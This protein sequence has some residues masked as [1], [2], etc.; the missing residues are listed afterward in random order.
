MDMK[1]IR[2][3]AREKLKPHC[4]VCPVCNG[5][6]CAGE[7]PGMGGTGTGETFMENVR[8]LAQW[9]L[10]LRTLHDAA[11]FDTTLDL[12]GLTLTSPIMA[13]PLAGLAA[14][15]DKKI[16]E[17]EML[18]DLLSG[19]QASGSLSWTGDGVNPAMFTA[20]MD[21]IKRHKGRA[22]VTIKPRGVP[23]ILKRV[24]MAEEAGALAVA[25][26]VD[27]AGFHAMATRGQ[28]VG[29]TNPPDIA[30]IIAATHLPV[31]V[32]GIMTP[33][34]ASLAA[35]LGVAGIV[36]S[37]HGG[38]ALDACLGTADVLPGIASVVKGKT[39]IFFDGGVRTGSDILKV[40]ALGAEGVL[41]GR[42]MIVAAAGGGAQGVRALMS[43]LEEELVRAMTLTGVASVNHVPSN[44]VTRLTRF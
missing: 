17:P 36:I 24:R 6:V 12:W 3:A 25:I 7:V 14:H 29:P 4:R 35:S 1:Q 19:C 8:A 33:D 22:I 32:K 44:I 16:D 31:I 21:L 10:N 13:A 43:T 30:A 5:R 23:E 42:P 27:S 18:E 28:P 38:R 40:L 26:D 11:P 20:A 2:D 41:L 39:R 9:K 15:F 37:N 34:E